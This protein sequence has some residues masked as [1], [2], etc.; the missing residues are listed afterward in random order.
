LSIARRRREA[1]QEADRRFRIDRSD[2]DF[3]APP[4]SRKERNELKLLRRL[5]PAEPSQNLS[6][7]E[8]D[9]FETRRDHPFAHELPAPDG[10]FYPRHS[11]LYP[12][13]LP[14]AEPR[15]YTIDDLAQ[16]RK[17]LDQLRKAGSERTPLTPQEDAEETQLAAPIAVYERNPELRDE[18][19]IRELEERRAGSPLTASDEGELRDLRERYPEFAAVMHLMDLRYLYERIRELE[20]A[21][22]AGLDFD[23]MCK[24]AEV[25]CLRLRDPSKYLHEWQAQN[26]VRD[27]RGKAGRSS[28]SAA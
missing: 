2:G 23:A 18:A 19:R 11:K 16:D 26:H 28:R 7:F 9:G 25:I 5:Y 4:L 14:P 24:Q 27:R 6:P 13:K 22:K 12:R 15:G 17:R 8:D 10:N 3:H 21:R 1:L 20:I